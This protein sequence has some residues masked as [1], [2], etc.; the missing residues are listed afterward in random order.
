MLLSK[1]LEMY[2]ILNTVI[3]K[4]MQS[5]STRSTAVHVVYVPIWRFWGPQHS[6]PNENLPHVQL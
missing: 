3:I 4:Y 6:S 2:Y 1:F 5:N